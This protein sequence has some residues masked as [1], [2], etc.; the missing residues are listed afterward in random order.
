MEGNVEQREPAH[1]LVAS[2]EP[3]KPWVLG[4]AS[5]DER[6][7]PAPL[8]RPYSFWAECEC[9]DDCPRDHDNE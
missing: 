1:R 3:S 4:L 9:P 7:R 5:D 2:P 6:T 8:L